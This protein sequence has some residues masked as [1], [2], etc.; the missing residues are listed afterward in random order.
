MYKRQIREIIWRSRDP[1]FGGRIA[2][3]EDYDMG[4]AAL[5][6]SGVDVW[7]NNPRAPLEASGTSGMKAAANGVPN[8]SILDGWW[9]EGWQEQPIN[10]WGIEPSPLTG[11]EQDNADANTLYD[12]IEKQVA[13]LYYDR[14][15]DGRP[16]RW[17]K[18]AKTAMATNAPEFSARRMVLDYIATLYTPAA[19]VTATVGEPVLTT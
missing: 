16:R 5:L 15:D 1:R 9:D 13:P 8:L 7:M 17:I 19:T 2:F 4:V 11:W 6:V 18:V 14:D 10:G 3:A 12:V